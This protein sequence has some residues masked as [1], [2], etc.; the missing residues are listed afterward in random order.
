MPDAAA[1][2]DG[3]RRSELLAAWSV[4]I[5]VA[6]GAPMESG[7]RICLIA[8]RIAAVVGA[9]LDERIRT[10]HLAL[11]RH[12]GC[13]AANRDLV[14]VIGDEMAFRQGMEGLDFTSIR[15][16]MP[17][18]VKA[19]L[20]SRPLIARPMA[21]LSFPVKAKVLTSTSAAICE[22]AQMLSARLGLVSGLSGDLA[23][24][25]ERYDGKGF[26][27][28]V[29]GSEVSLPAQV[30]QI[31]ESLVIAE[32]LDGRPGAMRVLNARRGKAF[33]PDLVDAVTDAADEI[34]AR[35]DGSEWDAVIDAE[36]GSAPRLAGAALDDA[37]RAFGDFVD[38][39]SPYTA[40]HSAHVAQ[41]AGDAADVIGMPDAE[42]RNARRAGWVHDVGRVSVPLTVWEKSSPLT[43]DE[44]EQVRL[45]P[46]YTARI[47][48]RPALLAS[49]ARIGSAHHERLDGSGYHQG[50]SA[51][52]QSPSVRL[53]A[54]ADFLAALVQD[55]PQRPAHQA[56]D[57]ARVLR[58]AATAGRL[59]PDAV[60]AVLHAAGHP[61]SRRRSNVAGLTAREL[62]VLRLLAAGH[63][64]KGIASALVV[65]P[66]TVG[67]HI[68]SIYAKAAVSTRPGA[69]MFAMQHGL[70]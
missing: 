33:R 43:R 2:T 1:P 56:A 65:S 49:I 51:A 19:M 16:L 66:K 35:V 58:A 44:W 29:A 59:D 28:R 23:Q 27:N 47:L 38:M 34:L 21:M 52:T 15:D 5:D 50:E 22:V 41:L 11:L 31:A 54:A 18:M 12:I 53:L 13:T 8:T 42:I 9:D 55:R 61:V 67:H 4:A 14:N 68:E 39:K 25:Y 3:L 6:M 7:L 46:Y 30:V 37:L 60:D 62:E 26:P 63:S 69:T 45:H 40:G 24:V 17:Y 57:A 36:P 48:S 20:R 64:N 70:V 10:Y 32:E